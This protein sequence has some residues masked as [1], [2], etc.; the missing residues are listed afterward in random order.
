MRYLVV[1]HEVEGV[2]KEDAFVGPFRS[3]ERAKR[4]AAL[5]EVISQGLLQARV[6]YI[7]PGTTSAREVIALWG[8]RMVE[9]VAEFRAAGER[10]NSAGS[11]CSTFPR[12]RQA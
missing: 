11:V 6:E 1:V 12:E 3:E 5:V 8:P 10:V 4:K 9:K 2:I 7:D